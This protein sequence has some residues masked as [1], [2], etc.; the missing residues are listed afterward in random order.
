MAE[1]NLPC[2]ISRTSRHTHSHSLITNTKF[3]GH[4]SPIFNQTCEPRYFVIVPRGRTGMAAV[5]FGFSAGDFV[6]TIGLVK[7][8]IKA[9]ND[10]SGAR[11]AYQRLRS[12]LLNL[13][14]ALTQVQ[15]LEVDATQL[16]QKAALQA[17]VAQCHESINRFLA[18][19][20][21]FQNTLGQTSSSRARWRSTLHKVQWALLKDD[22]IEA[23]RAEL[24]GHTTTIN[25]IVNL[26]QAATLKINIDAVDNFLQSLRGIENN[27]RETNALVVKSHDL[28][29]VQSDMMVSISQAVAALA[30]D[31][32]VSSG[33]SI[34]E[35]ILSYNMKIYSMFLEMQAMLWNEIPTQVNRQQPVYFEDAHGRMTSFHVEWINCFE[36]FQAALETHFRDVPGLVKVERLEYAIRDGRSRNILNI[37]TGRWN[38]IFLP[39]RKFYMSVIFRQERDT[40]TSNCPACDRRVVSTHE[41]SSD[42]ETQW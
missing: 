34:M 7:D 14:D 25:L 21:K 11:P 12:E 13:D 4:F 38:S 23:L 30:A 40:A 26:I 18:R 28:L 19:N 9:L 22:S 5:P 37:R 27:E 3:P 29:A 41:E 2:M 6:A 32:Q 36:A 16:S 1:L 31:N 10:T 24:A 8:A 17:V 42:I 15:S 35:Q 20:A 33:Q 39:G